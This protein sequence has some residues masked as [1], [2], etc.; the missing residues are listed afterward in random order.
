MEEGGDRW[1]PA[2]VGTLPLSV[3]PP[4]S[5]AW[6][7]RLLSALFPQLLNYSST[8]ASLTRALICWAVT[9]LHPK[10][11]YQATWPKLSLSA[12]QIFFKSCNFY[13]LVREF[14]LSYLFLDTLT[15]P[16]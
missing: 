3:F 10:Q 6:G 4:W 15:L 2:L 14:L 5:W 9:V 8:T 11:R 16:M 1:Q 13:F 12:W 7:H